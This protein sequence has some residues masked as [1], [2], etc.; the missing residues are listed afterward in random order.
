M[1]VTVEEHEVLING[2]VFINQVA[3]LL[4]RMQLET[5]VVSDAKLQV[6]VP[7]TRSDILHPCDVA[8]VSL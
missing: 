7:P 6:S 2:V 3:E 8:E 5:V 4:T 1:Y